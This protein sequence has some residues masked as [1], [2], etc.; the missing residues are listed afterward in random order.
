MSERT[1]EQILEDLNAITDRIACADSD[2]LDYLVP[3]QEQLINEMN[4]HPENRA[5]LKPVGE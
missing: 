5:A 3:V 4:F 2:E 1:I